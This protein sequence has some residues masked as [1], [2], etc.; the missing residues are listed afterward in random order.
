MMPIKVSRQIGRKSYL[1]KGLMVPMANVEALML[2]SPRWEKEAVQCNDIF[3]S[4][5][6]FRQISQVVAWNH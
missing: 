2:W 4:R 6:D 3:I 1:K 5:N